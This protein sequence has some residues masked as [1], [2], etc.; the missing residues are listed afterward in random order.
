M[1]FKSVWLARCRAIAASE[2]STADMRR[3]CMAVPP[4][5]NSS[6]QDVDCKLQPRLDPLEF[7]EWRDTTNH[8]RERH[9]TTT[10]T[11]TSQHRVLAVTHLQDRT[12]S[13]DSFLVKYPY[14]DDFRFKLIADKG[15]ESNLS[16]SSTFRV[17]KTEPAKDPIRLGFDLHT[18]VEIVTL[19]STTISAAKAAKELNDLLRKTNEQKV[20]LQSPFRT[21]ELK[22]ESTSE[23]QLEEFFRAAGLP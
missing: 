1:L 20:V 13:N 12:C 10:V 8:Q 2:S 17:E 21:I 22:P 18:I 4:V 5:R 7:S 15:V 16:E 11:S 19:I 3:T 6:D 23:P 14:M 9:V